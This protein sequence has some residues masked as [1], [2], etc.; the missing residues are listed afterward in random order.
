MN[1]LAIALV[2]TTPTL[3]VIKADFRIGGQP[4]IHQSSTSPGSAGTPLQLAPDADA[5]GGRTAEAQNAEDQR[6]ADD[7][8]TAPVIAK[9]HFIVAHG[10]GQR[11]PLAFAIRQVVPPRVQVSYGEGVDQAQPVSWNGGRPWD[12]VLRAAV[13]PLG[14][15]VVVSH[16]AVKIIE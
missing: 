13:R 3:P 4:L 10:F 12:Q 15:H 5:D 2:V 1:L 8:D 9:P 16:M 11:V 6:P 14:L 7:S